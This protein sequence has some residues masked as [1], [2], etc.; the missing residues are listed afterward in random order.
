M[1]DKNG[2]VFTHRQVFLFVRLLNVWENILV[3]G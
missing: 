1:I 3:L 2:Y